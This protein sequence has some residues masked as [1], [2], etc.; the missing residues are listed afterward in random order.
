[1]IAFRN[2]NLKGVIAHQWEHGQ[3][4][5]LQKKLYI[6]QIYCPVEKYFDQ[7]AKYPDAV[8]KVRCCP[9]F[10]YY[11]LL[12][13]DTP[14]YVYNIKPPMGHGAKIEKPNP[15][16][17]RLPRAHHGFSQKSSDNAWG[18]KP[19]GIIEAPVPNVPALNPSSLDEEQIESANKAERRRI[20]PKKNA[21]IPEDED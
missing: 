1:M 21:P 5:P 13:R 12:C 2:A 18:A 7:V 19:E 17:Y 10:D 11:Q 16:D 4:G 6:P 3:Y 15:R 8:Y 14:G 20:A 9:L